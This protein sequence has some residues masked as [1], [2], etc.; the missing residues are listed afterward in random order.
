M[1]LARWRTVAGYVVLSF[2][3]AGTFWV[4]PYLPTNDGPEWVFATHLENHYNDPGTP[5]REAFVP[6]AQFAS[7]G[8]ATIY[9]PLEAWLGWQR[10]LQVALSL[11]V[12]L[13]GWG[14][15]VLA[16]AIE[17]RRS[18]LGFLGFPLALSWGL[19]MGFWSFTI[20][21][22]LGLGVIA[23]AARVRE[24]TWPITAGLSAIL[25]V[26]AVAHVFSAVLTGLV[27]LCVLMARAPR[28]RRLRDASRVAVIG[29]PSAMILVGAG[30]AASDAG[31]PILGQSFTDLPWRHAVAVFPQTLAPGPMPRAVLVTIAVGAA[32]GFAAYRLR[33]SQT[34][35]LDRGLAVA[36]IVLL[37]AGVFAPIR[38]PGWWFFSQRF[39]PLG[40]T[41]ALAVIPLER[42]RPELA[43]IVSGAL[44]AAAVLWVSPTYAF[45]RRLA[46]AC[47]DAV[48]GL[49][50]P[51]HRSTEQL[52]IPLDWTESPDADLVHAEVP[53]M[54]PLLHMGA[55]YAAVQGGLTPLSF[56]NGGA[57]Y[58]FTQK[59][60]AMAVPPSVLN[61]EHYWTVFRSESFR[62]D[63]A[64]RHAVE[65]ELA[66]FG[67]HY[68]GI[69]LLAAHPDDVAL[70]HSRGYVADWEHGKTLIAHYDPCR[71]SGRPSCD[72]DPVPAQ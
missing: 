56:G 58:P 32:A 41:L 10:G 57:T 39:L 9:N 37:L 20:A 24:P 48:L 19:Y 44:F 72:P 45:H 68:E 36:A 6:A 64:Y 67:T 66:S 53:L 15:V 8:F 11:V 52:P 17:P 51:V 16:H 61:L 34:S 14:F 54:K 33:A 70:W 23:V 4:I 40:A 46:S 31:P 5:Y 25:L 65:E 12:V 28:E 2:V 29:L 1:A 69:V 55:L 71:A 43:R 7:R 35:P 63:L 30:L 62:H 60:H 21:S 18:A 26:V 47:S 50:A 13:V 59:P 3:V 38:V 27:V 22:G 49:S 42:L